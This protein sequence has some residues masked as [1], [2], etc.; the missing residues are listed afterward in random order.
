MAESRGDAA[1]CLSTFYFLLCTA[2]RGDAAGC[3]SALSGVADKLRALVTKQAEFATALQTHE[4]F[5]SWCQDAQAQ[6]Q[7]Q[8]AQVQQLD[9]S[10]L[11][12][13]L[14]PLT[15]PNLSSD[16]FGREASGSGRACR[17]G[18]E[19]STRKYT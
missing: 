1:S 3:G 7:H 5:A 4:R 11:E 15:F 19:G 9:L 12:L 16:A 10:L 18:A 2:S 6:V 17:G 8:V 14:R 13:S